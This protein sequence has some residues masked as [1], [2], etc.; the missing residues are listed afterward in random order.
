MSKLKAYFSYPK[1]QSPPYRLLFIFNDYYLQKASIQAL[2][3]MGHQVEVVPL[4]KD[5]RQMLDVLL[6]TSVLFR[7]DAIMGMNHVGMDTEGIIPQ[8]LAELG[9]PIIIWYLDDFRFLIPNQQALVTPLTAI[10]TFEQTHVPLLKAVGFEHVFYLPSASAYDPHQDYHHRYPRFQKLNEAVTFVGTTFDYTRKKLEQPEFERFYQ[11]FIQHHNLAIHSPNMV[12][13]LENRQR[14][15]FA[16]PA[17]FYEYC[18]YVISRSTETYRLHFLK[19]V[20]ARPFYVIGDA[21]WLTLGVPA[22]YLP[23]TQYET[24]TPAVYAHSQINLNLSS[25]QLSTTVS[26]RPFD[27]SAA[28]GFL[29]SDYTESLYELFEPDEI[30]SFRTVEEMNDLIHYYR[31]HPAQREKIAQKARQKVIERH[32]IHH[33]M[34]TILDT[35]QQLWR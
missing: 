4:Q 32:Q 2:K 7:P 17:Q 12:S 30:P 21:R 24:E 6:K 11:E 13:D 14:H 18:G 35:M 3:Q 1:F 10:F 20:E 29:I 19:A 22:Q 15:L 8:T 34:Q 33:R 26:L 5:A 28:G 23:P 9:I 31:Q 16:D 27:V 25:L